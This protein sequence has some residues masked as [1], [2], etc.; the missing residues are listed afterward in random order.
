MMNKIGAG[1]GGAAVALILIIVVVAAF[2]YFSYSPGP[3]AL[4]ATEGVEA[5]Y[6]FP[7]SVTPSST[8]GVNFYV[9]NNLAGGS[10][11][12][13]NLCLDNLGLF[14]LASSSSRCVKIPSLFAG[15]TLFE[16]FSLVAPLSSYYGNIPYSQNLGYFIN[17]SYLSS[18]T[19]SFVFLSPSTI[20]SGKTGPVESFSSTAGPVGIATSVS[21]QVAYG[22]DAYLELTLSNVG[23]GIPI[24]NV[25]MN[26]SMDTAFINMTSLP[27]GVKVYS[28]P[29][30]TTVFS[31]SVDLGSG[32]VNMQLPIGL[33]SSELSGLTSTGVP[34]SPPFYAHISLG[35]DYEEDGAFPITLDTQT[36]YYP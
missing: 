16:S 6:S 23:N 2:L 32:S 35:Y 27:A 1:G 22:N 26:I 15:G 19:Q 24:S 9:S 11:S 5:I 4:P 17:F 3:A 13:I 10:A 30:G 36:Y 18:A 33:S 8:F 34:N 20:S 21:P 12:N 25:D 14:S 28:Y 7:A 29:N 31:F